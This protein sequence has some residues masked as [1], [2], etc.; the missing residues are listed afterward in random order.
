MNLLGVCQGG[1]LALC[2]TALFPTLIHQ[3]IT[4]ATPVD[5]HV[6]KAVLKNIVEKIDF[7]PLF[8][9][10][11]NLPGSVISDLLE[12]ISPFKAE[13]SSVLLANRAVSGQKNFYAKMCEWVYDSPDQA[14]K[15]FMT[16][17]EEVIIENKLIHKKLV[18]NH[19]IID[20]TS[21]HIPVL[22]IYATTDHLW[23]VEITE[24]L[25]KYIPPKYY[26]EYIFEG[27]HLGMMVSKKGLKDISTVIG[28]WI[29]EKI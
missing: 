6:G 20:L 9:I 14:G 10:Y 11:G 25:K 13:F 28:Q 2:Y 18:I 27:T 24:A 23:P 4:I 22:N 7:A 5:F 21:I 12:T 15:M 3:L 17:I 16:F 1:Y 29:V 8:N 19:K 26:Q